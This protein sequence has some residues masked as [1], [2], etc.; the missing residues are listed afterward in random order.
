MFIISILIIKVN[1]QPIKK[2]KMDSNMNIKSKIKK[3]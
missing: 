2:I 3:V 1:T